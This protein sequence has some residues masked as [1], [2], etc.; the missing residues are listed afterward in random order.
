VLEPLGI[1]AV[2]VAEPLEVGAD[3]ADELAV[4]VTGRRRGVLGGRLGGTRG[5][6]RVRRLLV[7]AG[8]RREIGRA[9]CRERV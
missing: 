5:R 3:D 7:F 6:G 1:V 2:G 9:S 4:P 8:Q